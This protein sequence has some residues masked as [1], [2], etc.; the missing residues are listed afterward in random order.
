MVHGPTLPTAA[1]TLALSS[2]QTIHY[3][4]WKEHPVGR[5]LLFATVICQIFLIIF[6]SFSYP[7]ISL[8][9]SSSNFLICSTHLRYLHLPLHLGPSALGNERAVIPAA[10]L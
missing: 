5:S 4:H 10:P 3:I 1:S 9:T 8:L 7:W 6:L 2:T